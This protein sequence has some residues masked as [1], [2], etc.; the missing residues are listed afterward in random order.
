M[1]IICL[2]CLQQWAKLYAGSE[3]RLVGSGRYTYLQ[4]R[5]KFPGL[6][7]LALSNLAESPSIST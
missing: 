2:H 1:Q 3:R 7:I 6:E 5:T 4:A